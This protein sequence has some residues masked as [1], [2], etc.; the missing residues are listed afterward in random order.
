MELRF[1]GDVRQQRYFLMHKDSIIMEFDFKQKSHEIRNHKL[2]PF[3]LQKSRDMLVDLREWLIKRTLPLSRK[4]AD[5]MYMILGKPRDRSGALEIA[6]EYGALSL[7]DPYW[8]KAA[9]SGIC[10]ED[11]NLYKKEW[12]RIFGLIAITGSRNITS[13]EKLS[14]ELTLIGSWAKCLIREDGDIYLLK[15]SMDEELKDIEAEVTVSKL[16][17]ALNIP[18]AEYESAEYEDVF[19]SKTKILT[20][21]YMHWVSADEFIDFSGCS[22]L[23]EMGVKYGKDN[24]LKMIICDYVTGNIDRHHQNW[25]FEYDDQ[26]E[27]MGLS[28]LFDFNF[29]FCGT[30]DRKSQFGADNTDFEVAV[31]VIE[32]FH[33]E[34]FLEEVRNAVSGLDAVKW[35]LDYMMS[36]IER[37]ESGLE[38][39]IL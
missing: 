4:N 28:P 18:H 21:E 22:N 2:M 37:L 6:L 1:E 15:A 7:F 31:Y 34:A 30:V 11:V 8:I 3:Y 25:A 12:D 39:T 14:P 29:A 5:F 9:D 32:T 10:Y 24:F 20:T 27:V 13:L 23:F 36:R 35:H 16:L 19:C 38:A 17:G 26:N 33:M